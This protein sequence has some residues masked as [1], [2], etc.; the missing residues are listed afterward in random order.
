MSVELPEQGLH[1][2]VP[3]PIYRSWPCP[4]YSILKH[5]VRS[6]LHAWTAMTEP[7]EPTPAMLLGRA[8]HTAI[9]EPQL[10]ADSYCVRPEGIDRRTKA[11]RLAWDKFVADNA[12]KDP[13]AVADHAKVSRMQESVWENPLASEILASPGANE[14]SVLWHE[15][16]DGAAC[17]IKSRIDAIRAWDGTIVLDVKTCQ[18]ASADEFAKSCQRYQ[19][20]EQAALYLRGLDTIEPRPRRWLWVAVE[21]KAPYAVKVYEA[22]ATDLEIA[23][24]RVEDWIDTWATCSERHDFPGYPPTVEAVEMPRWWYQ[25][26]EWN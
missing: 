2:D 25:T 20:V 1:L 17:P 12:G 11:G 24:A 23:T 14:V 4:S 26:H 13:L 6:P 22:N 10:F 18:D 3:E 8:T 21:N 16:A 5:T 7:E 19:Y 15:R 9:L